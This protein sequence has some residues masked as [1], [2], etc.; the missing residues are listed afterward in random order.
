[1]HAMDIAALE[2]ARK[3]L[4]DKGRDV[5]EMISLANLTDGLSIRDTWTDA[6][7]V[8]QLGIRDRDVLLAYVARVSMIEHFWP[9]TP[10]TEDDD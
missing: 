1:M 3:A 8:S 7:A 9:D 6:A 4:S 10:E 2:S 5:L